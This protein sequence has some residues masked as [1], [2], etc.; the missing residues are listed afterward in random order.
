MNDAAQEAASYHTLHAHSPV[1]SVR[2]NVHLSA[3]LC[4]KLTYP[5][6]QVGEAL[7]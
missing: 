2:T 3:P 1:P 4:V 6:A 7:D 5:A